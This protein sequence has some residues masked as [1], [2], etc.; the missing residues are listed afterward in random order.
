M[1]R[2]KKN[3]SVVSGLCYRYQNAKRETMKRIHDGAVGDIVAL[4]CA[5]NTGGL[6]HKDRQPELERHGMADPQLALLH[7]AVGRSQRRAAH[8]QPRQDGVGDEG[9]VAG[10]RVGLGGRQVRTEQE[11]RPH[12]RPSRRRLRV[13]NGV[14]LFS[15]CRQQDGTDIEVEDYVLGTLGTCSVQQHTI[16]GKNPWKLPRTATKSDDMYQNEHN[17][18][19]ASI[20]AGKPINNGDYMCQ[21]TL[22]AIMGRMATYTGKVITWEQALNSKQDLSPKEY[23]FGDLATPEVALPGVTKFS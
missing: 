17:E 7:L 5:Y 1:K 2:K 3:L 16:T 18:L 13:P 21:S 15:Y 9:R 12:L 11:V 20:R 4:H 23:K 19:F 10:Q 14:K 22:M 6:W 8:P